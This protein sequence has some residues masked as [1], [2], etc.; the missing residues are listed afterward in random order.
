LN[1]IRKFCKLQKF[2][3][4]DVKFEVLGQKTLFFGQ[5]VRKSLVKIFGKKLGNFGKSSEISET[6]FSECLEILEILEISEIWKF[7]TFQ[8]L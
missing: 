5:K 6:G 7:R 2:Q 1:T 3:K 8:K 4:N